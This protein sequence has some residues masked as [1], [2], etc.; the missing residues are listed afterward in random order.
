MMRAKSMTLCSKYSDDSQDIF[1]DRGLATI[2][3]TRLDGTTLVNVNSDELAL[4]AG[5]GLLTMDDCPSQVS[6][7]QRERS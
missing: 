4:N 6:S 5:G 1:V 2:Q 7:S 3:V